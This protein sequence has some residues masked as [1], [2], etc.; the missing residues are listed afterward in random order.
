MRNYFNVPHCNSKECRD[1][2]TVDKK[3][4]VHATLLERKQNGKWTLAV[5]ADNPKG[6]TGI[7]QGSKGT[8]GEQRGAKQESHPSRTGA[9]SGEAPHSGE[10]GQWER[11]SGTHNSTTDLC[12]PKYRIY[13]LTP[14][15]ASRLT[16][17]SALFLVR[18]TSQAHKET[19]LW[20]LW[21][22]QCQ[23]P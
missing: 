15:Q 9:E 10:K 1:F 21:E 13:P 2:K 20:D 18:I 3:Q 6:H 8:H 22:P 14:P 17:K 11:A 19:H 5:Q 7:Y 23:L 12:N 4:L 16:Q